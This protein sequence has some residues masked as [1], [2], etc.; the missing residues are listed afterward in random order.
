MLVLAIGAV[1]KLNNPSDNAPLPFP[2]P[3]PTA[4]QP[5]DVLYIRSDQFLEAQGALRKGGP[6][7][8]A[9]L[10][11]HIH[12]KWAKNIV[13]LWDDAY[14]TCGIGSVS[15]HS[16]PN[17]NTVVITAARDGWAGHK[18]KWTVR[19]SKVHYD[20]ELTAIVYGKTAI[21]QEIPTELA[22]HAYLFDLQDY[23]EEA[24]FQQTDSVTL[25]QHRETTMTHS[26]EMNYTL[27]VRNHDRRLIRGCE[28]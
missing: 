11:E 26:T 25:E 24:T 15:T 17:D 7:S 2:I 6:I 21:S 14:S 1:W 22:G 27:V 23:E 20:P 13:A 10:M 8:E 28:P 5:V 19:F 18:G 4:D 16:W 12:A 9:Y 3:T